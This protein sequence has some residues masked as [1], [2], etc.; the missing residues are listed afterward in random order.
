MNMILFIFIILAAT[1]ISSSTNNLMSVATA[2]D[3]YFEKAEMPDYWMITSSQTE[4]DKFYEFVDKN[5]YNCKTLELLQID[6]NDV[7]INGEKF[8]Y[9]NTTS[10]SSLENSTKVFDSNDEEITQVHDG[11][12]FVTAKIFYN[13]KYHLNAGDTITIT[14]DG[15]T[16]EFTLKGCTKDAAFGSDQMGVT[17]ML[18]SEND[19]KFFHS[20]NSKMFYSNFVYTNDSDFMDKVNNTEIQ[21]IFSADHSIMEIMYL[22]D[23]LIAAIILVVSLCLIIVSM[24]I[25]RFTI[26]FTMSEELREIGVMKAIGI[27]N[28]KIRGLYIIK[29][30]AI[31]VVGAMIGF[32]LSIPFGKLLIQ[33]VSRNIIIGS[34]G[35]IM[36]NLI[37]AVGTALIV[38]M[39]CY[40]CTRKIKKFSPIDA[41]RSGES[42]ERY[43][44]KGFIHLSKTKLSPIPFMAVN[45]I[46]SGLRRFSAMIAIFALGLLLIIIPENTINTLKSD[47]LLQWFNMAP[48]DHVISEEALLNK[49]DN[50]KIVEDKL[51][52]VRDYL[53]ENNI[54]ADVFEEVI[55][56]MSISY[57]DKKTTSIAFQGVGDVKADDYMYDKGSAPSNVN[58]VAITELIAEKIN[59]KIGDDVQIQNGEEIKTYT[60]C[61][62]YQ[63][64]NNMGE[65][66]RFHHEEKLD[67]NYAS[68]S[69]GIQIRYKDNPDSKIVSQRKSLLKE[70]YTDGKVCTAGEYIDMMIGDISGQIDSV[71]MMIIVVVLCI[72]ILV[73]VLM[74]KSF[75][76]KEKSEIAIL[77]AIG[78]RNSSLVAWQTIRI[79]IVL[80]IA[81]TLA[82]ALSTPLSHLTIEPIFRMMGAQKIKFEIKP[83]EVFVIYPLLIL[84]VTT[85]S[86]MLTATQIRKI[87]ASETSNN[88]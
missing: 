55:F 30:F 71:K 47:N 34:S 56:R 1:F 50:K 78:F 63:S 86:G 8:D 62:L 9:S 15:K 27:T 83:M 44:G 40:F 49:S 3:N 46:F 76:T 11:E 75:L 87:Q 21:F 73:T 5:E 35:R 4:N 51:K 41:I 45:D 82:A 10:I 38:V 88:E 69:F 84:V 54:E 28:R 60:V 72:N 25:L 77:K 80:F 7:L 12:I 39:F 31:S 36:I 67:Y 74:V 13:E 64:M 32:L 61:G 79:G 22:M 16:K 37:C 58:E 23:M 18:I 19:F 66:I 33:D 70:K 53:T 2:L 43:T 59:V 24:L 26:N 57:K 42:G 29:Y 52:D 48:C 20:N 14:S 17:R 6:P 81:I 85:L 68:G 65:G